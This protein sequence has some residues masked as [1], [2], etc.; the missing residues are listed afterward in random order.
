MEFVQHRAKTEISSYQETT[1]YFPQK[2]K[3]LK[4]NL[5]KFENPGRNINKE[6]RPSNLREENITCS[7][8]NYCFESSEKLKELSLEDY[9]IDVNLLSILERYLSLLETL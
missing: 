3:N 5:K 7:K 8:L 6:S 4:F 9:N 2:K 1:S